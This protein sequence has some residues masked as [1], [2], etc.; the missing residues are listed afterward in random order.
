MAEALAAVA[1]A[2]AA[3]HLAAADVTLVAIA[4]VTAD[5]VAKRFDLQF[6]M[7]NTGLV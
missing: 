2:L 5:A 7:A 3:A 1:E 4:V 6:E